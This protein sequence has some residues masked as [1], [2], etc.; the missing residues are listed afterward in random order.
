MNLISTRII[1]DDVDRLADFY[2]AVTRGEL[3]R[4]H[5]LFAEVRTAGGTVAIGATETVGLF[6]PGSLEPA[7]N[8]SAIV[9]FLVADVDAEHDRLRRDG[10]VTE[11]VTE[12]TDMPWGNRSLLFRDPDG[13][14]VNLFTPVSDAAVQKFQ[15]VPR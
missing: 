12:P 8:R 13:T 1:T 2:A 7:A 9:E 6:A 5:P 15:G 14:M 10:V 11:F 3:V 4:P